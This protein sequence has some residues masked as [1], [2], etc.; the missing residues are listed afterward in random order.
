MS[1]F[2]EKTAGK[3]LIYKVRHRA[4]IW[5][6]WNL[7][8]TIFVTK[9][10]DWKMNEEEDFRFSSWLHVEMKIL[11]KID[12]DD[13][14]K[15]NLNIFWFQCY[16]ILAINHPIRQPLRMAAGHR[17]SVIKSTN[18]FKC[19]WILRSK[20]PISTIFFNNSIKFKNNSYFEIL[21]I[22]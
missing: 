1:S 11:K 6:H 22:A 7:S 21:N 13:E 16:L 2:I 9:T 15:L 4:W 12:R 8:F 18:G 20:C 17:S 14:I 3:Q 5:M 19:I 10:K